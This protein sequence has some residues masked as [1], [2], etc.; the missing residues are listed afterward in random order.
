MDT[1]S[2]KEKVIAENY[3]AFEAMLPLLLQTHKGEFA[4]L[5]DRKVVCFFP[6]ASGAQIE[7]AR[8]YPD[9]SFS[10]QKVEDK[11]IDLG[12]YSYARYRRVA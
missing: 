1:R 3:E 9:G 12:F 6:T 7:G 8:R 5:N 10:V 11:A 4:L 2:A